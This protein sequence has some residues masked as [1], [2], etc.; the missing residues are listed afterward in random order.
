MSSNASDSSLQMNMKM[1][2]L[3]KT[4]IEQQK[5]IYLLTKKVDKISKAEK[6]L[7]QN[8]RT[9][10]EAEFEKLLNDS[11]SSEDKAYQEAYQEAF[12]NREEYMRNWDIIAKEKGLLPGEGLSSSDLGIMSPQKSQR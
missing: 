5:Q 3:A 12:N 8:D 7:N 1:R 6:L 11:V 2:F 9:V 10:N 4:S